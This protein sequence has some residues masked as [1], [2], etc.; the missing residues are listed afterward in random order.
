MEV[1]V[2]RVGGGD[3]K[4][5]GGGYTAGAPPGS[6][7]IFKAGLPL[8]KR[9]CFLMLILQSMLPGY[10]HAFKLKTRARTCAQQGYNPPDRKC[11]TNENFTVPAR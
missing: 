5:G 7:G 6:Y 3:C 1:T 4:G 2:S 10:G 8:A 11:M 9:H